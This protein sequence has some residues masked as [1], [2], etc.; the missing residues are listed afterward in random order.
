MKRVVRSGD[1]VIRFDDSQEIKDKVFESLIE[2][3][4]LKYGSFCGESI[5]QS[6]DPIIEAPV[7]LS[8]IADKIIKFDVEY[9]DDI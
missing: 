1:M 7:V 8:E 9:I 3:Y 4:Y 6:D 5:M 2:D